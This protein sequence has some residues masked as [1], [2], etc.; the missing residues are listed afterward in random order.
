MIL[1]HGSEANCLGTKANKTYTKYPEQTINFFIM[2]TMIVK[3]VK[4][5]SYSQAC[6]KYY[7]D[8]FWGEDLHQGWF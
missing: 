3:K 7:V 8:P 6:S 2:K 5:Q 4:V 1:T